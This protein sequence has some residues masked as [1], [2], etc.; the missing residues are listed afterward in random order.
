MT[1]A[2]A[3]SRL[4]EIAAARRSLDAE[5]ERLLEQL[6]A[7]PEGARAAPERLIDTS[8]ARR[9]AGV[10]NSTLYRWARRYDL[11]RKIGGTWRFDETSLRAFVAGR[12]EVGAADGEVGAVAGIHNAPDQAH[13]CDSETR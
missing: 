6:A 10:E 2:A 8:K 5:E 9:I 3:L 11:G 7:A 12:G 13:L 1:P 4:R